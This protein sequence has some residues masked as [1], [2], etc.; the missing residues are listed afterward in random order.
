[1]LPIDF[2]SGDAEMQFVFF[3]AW[4]AIAIGQFSAG[5]EGMH[6]YL[7]VGSFASFLLFVLSYGV[8][9]I[10][11]ILSAA[12][13]YYGARYGWHWE[14]WQA[15]ALAAPGIVLW[16]IAIAMGGLSDLFARRI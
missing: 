10:G 8:P 9:V 7:G 4:I 14:W 1:M 2:G 6:L 16:L 13:V 5:M 11:S 3:I 12:A 15:L